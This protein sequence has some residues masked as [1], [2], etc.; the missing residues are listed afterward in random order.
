MKSALERQLK[1]L[2]PRGRVL[3]SAAQLA[4]YGADGLGFKNYLP[5]A[6]VI[7]ADAE[8]MAGFMQGARRRSKRRNRAV[9]IGFGSC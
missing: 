6:V 7:P 8:E 3:I 5:D 1:A 2:L 9:G 4:G